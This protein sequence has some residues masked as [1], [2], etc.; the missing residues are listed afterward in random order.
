MR[1]P[2]TQIRER[3]P[4]RRLSGPGAVGGGWGLGVERGVSFPNQASGGRKRVYRCPACCRGE[5]V[6]EGLSYGRPGPSA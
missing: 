1:K 5:R 4:C 6:G 2:E 3:A